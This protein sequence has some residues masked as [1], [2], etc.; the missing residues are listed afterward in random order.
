MNVTIKWAI[1]VTNQNQNLHFLFDFT[2]FTCRR[3]IHFSQ[4]IV[5]LVVNVVGLIYCDFA[6]V[7]SCCLFICF[8]GGG[9]RVDLHPTRLKCSI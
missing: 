3:S 9:G 1:H 7:F 2:P 5:S 4:E 6:S 8:F